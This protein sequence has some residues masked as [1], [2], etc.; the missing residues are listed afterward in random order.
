MAFSFCHWRGLQEP[1]VPRWGVSQK[2]NK[3]LHSDVYSAG[4]TLLFVWYCFLNSRR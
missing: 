3:D 1:G 4:L 2:G